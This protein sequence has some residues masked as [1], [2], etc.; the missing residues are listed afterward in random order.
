[1][2]ECFRPNC[3]DHS[4]IS[5]DHVRWVTHNVKGGDKGVTGSGDRAFEIWMA[6]IVK[7]AMVSKT[8]RGKSF[9]VLGTLGKL[10]DGSRVFVLR[11]Y[12]TFA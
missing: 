11:C 1:M 8:A 5:S 2:Y 4:L 6:K 10:S 3:E 9:C 7:A 12:S